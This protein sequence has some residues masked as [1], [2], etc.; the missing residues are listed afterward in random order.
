M[1]KQGTEAEGRARGQTDDADATEGTLM[2]L[3]HATNQPAYDSRSERASER[4]DIGKK[5]RSDVDRESTVSVR[6]RAGAGASKHLRW[7]S[8][9]AQIAL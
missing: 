8:T 6:A 3:C 2:P 4:V 5:G 1:Q 9:D 7:P